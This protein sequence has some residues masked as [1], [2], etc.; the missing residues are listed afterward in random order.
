MGAKKGNRVEPEQAVCL[1]KS[2][3]QLWCKGERMA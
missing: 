2:G 1:R 3:Q